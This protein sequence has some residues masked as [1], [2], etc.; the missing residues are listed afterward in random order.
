MKTL[1]ISN[2]VTLGIHNRSQFKYIYD[3]ILRWR[4]IWIGHFFICIK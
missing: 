4:I 3:N 1:N 2:V